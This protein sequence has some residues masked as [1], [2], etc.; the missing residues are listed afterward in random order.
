MQNAEDEDQY[1]K[2]REFEYFVERMFP[3]S[4]FEILLDPFDKGGKIPDFYIRD[5]KTGQKFWVEAKWR[6]RSYDRKYTIGKQDRLTVYRVFQEIVRPETVFMVL[7]FGGRPSDPSEVFC[8]PVDE[9]RYS[10]MFESVLRN[11]KHEYTSFKY[12]SGKLF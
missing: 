1:A 9:V 3:H 12:E 2:G 4:D 7:G 10:Q 5:K 8:L 6:S 11:K